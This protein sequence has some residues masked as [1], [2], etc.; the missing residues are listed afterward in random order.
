MLTANAQERY[1]AVKISVLDSATNEEISSDEIRVINYDKRIISNPDPNNSGV[2]PMVYAGRI[3]IAI[4]KAGYEN[5]VRKRVLTCPESSRTSSKILTVLLSKPSASDE[6][7]VNTPLTIT[8]GIIPITKQ[9]INRI[10]KPRYPDAA[11]TL[12]VTGEVKVKVI[13]DTDGNVIYA[14]AVEGPP[15]LRRAAEDAAAGSVFKATLLNGKP[16]EVSGFIV[17]NFGS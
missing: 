4:K 8:R 15:L 13:I 14:R 11:K 3:S 12:R 1:C 17:Y 7:K 16:V 5:A 2:F 10:V 9:S 6:R